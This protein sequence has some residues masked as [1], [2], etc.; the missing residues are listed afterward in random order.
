[1]SRFRF[2]ITMTLDGYVAGPNQSVDN[3][4]GEGGGQIHEW[5]F[6][7]KSFQETH[8]GPGG[9]ETGVN[10]EILREA[11]AGIGATIMGRNMFGGGPGPWRKDPWRGWWGENPPFHTPV[12]VLTHHAREPLAM[13][14]GTTFYFVAD[15]IESALRQATDA[16]RG[17]DVALGGGASVARQYLAAGL[18]DEVEVHIVPLLLGGGE[19]LFD[20]LDGHNV[21]LE[22]IRAVQGP[23]VAHLKYRVVK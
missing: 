21:R 2:H 5:Q 22:Q 17:Q 3:P 12:F 6:R 1:M 7:A 9:G 19:R 4:I 15:G 10:D 18:L 8:G 13:Q 11:S 14:G 16:A 20:N 23:G